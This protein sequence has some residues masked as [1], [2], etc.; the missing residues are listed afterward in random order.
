MNKNIDIEKLHELILKNEDVG[1]AV[2][3]INGQDTNITPKKFANALRIIADEFDG[4]KVDIEEYN[5]LWPKKLLPSNY[6]ARS[7]KKDVER[8]FNSFYKKYHFDWETVIKATKRYVER[9]QLANWEYCKT[10]AYFI[11]KNGMSELA[12]EC[13]VILNGEE[14]EQKFKTRV[15]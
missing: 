9:K 1:L 6:Y 8:A 13:E 3:L 11:M 14:N 10:S 4:I 7:N 12:T 15:V 2:K 5:N